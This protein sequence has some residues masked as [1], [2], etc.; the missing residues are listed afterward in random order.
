MILLVVPLGVA[1]DELF[2]LL[3]PAGDDSAAADLADVVVPRQSADLH[4]ERLVRVGRRR[5]D[6]VDDGLE[7]GVHA[8]VGLGQVVDKPAGQSG[9]VEDREVGLLV[10]GAQFEEQVER[11][12]KRPFGVGVGPVNLVDDDNGPKSHR[13]S[14]GEHVAG[15][16]HG[17]FVGVHQKQDRVDH[18]EDA[19]HLAGEVGVSRRVDDVDQVV[20]PLHGAVLR[21]DGDAPFLFQLA[22]VHDALF[23]LTASAEG[24][25]RTE[26]RVDEGRL[27]VVDV[28]HDCHVA[29]LI[30]RKHETTLQFLNAR[31]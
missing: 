26:D 30:N 5:R 15:L 7:K 3:E 27:A 9:A 12:F 13:Q 16:R 23:L 31:G 20:M 18:R 4:E 6:L 14:A 17:A 10:R 11:F 1:V 19:F 2:A 25:S 8:L 24:L 22:A 21:R 29:D 28:G